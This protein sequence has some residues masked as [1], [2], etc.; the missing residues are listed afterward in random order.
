MKEKIQKKR[1]ETG[2]LQITEG[3]IWKQP[4]LFCFPILF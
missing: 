2:S 3:V 4:L 1:P